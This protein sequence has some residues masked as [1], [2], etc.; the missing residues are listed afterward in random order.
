MLA[1][2][3]TV[4]VSRCS[5]RLDHVVYAAASLKHLVSVAGQLEAQLV[6]GFQQ[7]TEK[8]VEVSMSHRE[9]A[10]AD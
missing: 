10:L 1:S 5:F 2:S 6:G 7:Q 4:V 8:A 9:L 3:V